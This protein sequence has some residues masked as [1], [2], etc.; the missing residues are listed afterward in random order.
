MQIQRYQVHQKLSAIMLPIFIQLIT[1]VKNL[2]SYAMGS[3]VGA[4]PHQAMFVNMPPTG[5]AESNF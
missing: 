2:I 5:F 3:S 4:I 1:M